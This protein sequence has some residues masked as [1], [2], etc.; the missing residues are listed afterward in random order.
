MR[1]YKTR[2]NKLSG[3]K[4]HEVRKKAFQIY[5]TIKKRSKRKPHIRSNYFKKQK[6]FLDL[7]WT[8]LFEKKNFV[9]LMRRIKFYPCALE[10]LQKS[11]IEPS[12]KQN[13]NKP[14]ESLHRF[15]GITP[16]RELFC[17]QVKENKK[18]NKKWLL[19]IF[20]KDK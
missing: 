2:V 17:V 5:L 8:H 11:T 13:P 15:L 14:G 16:Q 3:T 20:P 10:L 6:I 12:S 19:S 18:N 9:D 1:V 7:F 4:F